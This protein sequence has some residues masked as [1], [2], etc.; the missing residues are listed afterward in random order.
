MSWRV[1]AVIQTPAD[2]ELEDLERRVLKGGSLFRQYTK[3]FLSSLD[4]MFY[5]LNYDV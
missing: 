2:Q 3:F 5:T 1:A 4:M